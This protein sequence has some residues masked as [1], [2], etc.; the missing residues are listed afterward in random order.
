MLEYK[1]INDTPFEL[2]VFWTPDTERRI[3][4]TFSEFV[5]LSLKT[6]LMTVKVWPILSGFFFQIVYLP[7]VRG[8]RPSA[9]VRGGYLYVTRWSEFPDCDETGGFLCIGAA[10][11][12]SWAHCLRLPGDTTKYGV[13]WCLG[14]FAIVEI[15]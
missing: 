10:Y 7:A 15:D 11:G 14:Q 12:L 3:K 2:H 4:L 5:S 1:P 8:W 9:R 6:R 13:H